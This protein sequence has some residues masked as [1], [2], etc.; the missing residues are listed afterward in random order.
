[1]DCRNRPHHD[2]KET[3][4]VIRFLLVGVLNT[5]FGYGCYALLL[6]AGF[7][8]AVAALLA[9]IAGVLFNFQS[10]KRLVFQSRTSHRLFQFILS[11]CLIYV[12]NV[13]ILAVLIR[14]GLSAYVAGLI[15]LIPSAV[16]SYFLQRNWVFKR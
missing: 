13:V 8:Y 1:M 11:Y 10:S 9:T 4:V 12:I 14:F 16:M 3:L 6:A 15:N 5:A 7:H 2:G